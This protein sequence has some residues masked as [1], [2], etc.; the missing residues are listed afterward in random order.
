MYD[1]FVAKLR[2]PECGTTSAATSATNMQ[3]H[4]RDDADSSELGV[5]AHLDPLDVRP[6]DILNS[7]YQLVSR[8]QPGQPI[9]LLEVWNCPACGHANNWAMISIDVSDDATIEGIEAVRLDRANLD[10]AHFIS[11]SCMFV[12]AQLTG[13]SLEEVA[14]ETARCVGLLREL[15]P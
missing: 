7:G 11:D 12:A 6:D 5:G 3:T 14:S 1:W 9:R 10:K 15:L 13:A 4:L 2:C 8:P